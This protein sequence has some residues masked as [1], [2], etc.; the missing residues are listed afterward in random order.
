[1]FHVPAH[2][3]ATAAQVA[4][5]APIGHSLHPV[6][7]D[8]LAPLLARPTWSQAGY[9]EALKQRN[10]AAALLDAADHHEENGDGAIATELRGK[11]DAILA[12]IPVWYLGTSSAQEQRAERAIGA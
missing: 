8:A 1:M 2:K 9:E 4:V 3:S 10:E 6:M 7:Q 5:S 12:R 11:A